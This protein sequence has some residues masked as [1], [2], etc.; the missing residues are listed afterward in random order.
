MIC[1]EVITADGEERPAAA[2]QLGEAGPTRRRTS[3]RPGNRGVGRRKKRTLSPVAEKRPEQ[4]NT[5]L[6][7]GLVAGGVGLVLVIGII[8]DGDPAY[9]RQQVHRRELQEDQARDDRAGSDAL[10]GPPT[11]SIDAGALGIANKTVVWRN[12]QGEFRRFP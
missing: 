6:V 12:R 9:G 4:S 3:V 10:V 2:L 8:D 5:G 11:Q 1:E 7:I